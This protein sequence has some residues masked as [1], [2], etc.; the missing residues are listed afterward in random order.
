MPIIKIKYAINPKP[1]PTEKTI[2][3]RELNHLMP[4]RF[5]K[6][7]PAANAENKK[8]AVTKILKR[9]LKIRRLDRSNIPRYWSKESMI[10]R[11]FKFGLNIE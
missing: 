10:P 5:N 2:S 1:K 6:I 4:N 11:V 8:T 7:R 9:C 3:S